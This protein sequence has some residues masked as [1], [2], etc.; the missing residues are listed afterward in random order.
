MVPDGTLGEVRPFGTIVTLFICNSRGPLS[1]VTSP[2]ARCFVGGQRPPF[3]TRAPFRTLPASRD[4]GTARSP[5]R[6]RLDP[7]KLEIEDPC[8]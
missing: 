5:I 3:L 2:A 1:D 8:V 4:L 7:R 6:K